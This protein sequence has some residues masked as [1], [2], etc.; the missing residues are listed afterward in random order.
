M[1]LMEHALMQL[2]ST[3]PEGESVIRALS[4][5]AR[6]FNRQKNSELVPAQIME[7]AQANKPS[8]LQQMLAQQGAGAQPAA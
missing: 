6:H 5:L 2:G 4:T 8:P 1:Q 3:T 7:M